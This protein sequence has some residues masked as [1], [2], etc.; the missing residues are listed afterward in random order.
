FM[1]PA[2]AEAYNGQQGD[3]FDGQKDMAL[4]AIGALLSTAMLVLRPNRS[5]IRV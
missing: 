1:D 5:I 3:I 4:A 2:A